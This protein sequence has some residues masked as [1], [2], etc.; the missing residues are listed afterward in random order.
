MTFSTDTTSFLARCGRSLLLGMVLLCIGIAPA[1]AQVTGV[2]YTLSPIG[3][4]VYWEDDAGLEDAYLYGGELG[5]GFGEYLELGGIYLFNNEVETDFSDFSGDNSAVLDR[6]AA[7]PGRDVELRRYGGKLRL[8]V[9]RGSLVPFVTAGTGIIR[10]DVDG[11]GEHE[12]IYVAGGLGVTL[13]IDSRYTVSV[14]A[15]NLAYRYNPGTVFFTDADLREIGLSRA[16][17]NE[18]EVANWAATA[19]LKFYLG[20]RSRAELTDIDRALQRQFTGGDFRLAVEPFYGQINFAD[21]LHEAFGAD[22]T[23]AGINAGVDLGPYLGLRGF[24]WRGTE[25]ADALDTDLPDGFED[26]TLYGAELDLRFGRQLGSVAPYLIL[27]AG[28]AD[29]DGDFEEDSEGSRSFAT[30]GLGVE[31]P[32]SSALT[33]QGAARSVLMSTEDPDDLSAPSSVLASWMYTVGVAFNLG[34]SGRTVGGVVEEQQR[35]ARTRQAALEQELARLQGR[36]DSLETARATADSLAIPRTTRTVMEDTLVVRDDVDAARSNLSGRTITLPVPE[37]GEIYIRFGEPAAP[38]PS[39]PVYG[40]PVV[41]GGAQAYP[42]VRP[43][44]MG[45]QYRTGVGG[46]SA[47]EVRRLAREAARREVDARRGVSEDELENVENRLERRLDRELA[48][49]R[50]DLRELQ[51]RERVAER[52]ALRDTAADT[53]TTRRATA[54]SWV[55]SFQQREFAGALPFVGFRAGEGDEQFL[56]GGRADFRLPGRRARLWPEVALGIGSDVSL[57]AIANLAVPLDVVD[58]PVQPYVGA[59]LGVVTDSGIF[60]GPDLVLNALGGVSYTFTGGGSA[61]A[62]F[63]TLDFFDFNRVLVGYRIRF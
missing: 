11:T 6:I 46:L 52:Q 8:N 44:T 60:S 24:Y 58:L 2:S 17:F 40:P 33:V 27:G 22:Q 61:F 36:L 37:T 47:D 49:L 21:E 57:N 13:S 32:I 26:L 5:F 1:Q 25:D 23:V 45:M 42:F 3:S 53:V 14:A 55:A 20:G 9:G 56:I 48:R 51:E 15:E 38:A 12:Q 19:S 35:E 28:Y 43:D 62:E 34:G 39:E 16:A 7:L 59:G 54:N 4:R 30:G 31:L 63:S 29:L 10:F 18:Q 50:A 41:V